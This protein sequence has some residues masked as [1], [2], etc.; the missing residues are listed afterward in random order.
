MIARERLERVLK[1]L[2][3]LSQLCRAGL[4]GATALD[5][6]V[7]ISRT[8]NDLDLARRK[9]LLS[10]FAIEDAER[11]AENTERCPECFSVNQKADK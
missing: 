9:C 3:I 10:V 4:I 2:D 8:Q 11:F 7:D 1:D 5:D 6:K